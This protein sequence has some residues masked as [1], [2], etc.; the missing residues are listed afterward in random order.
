MSIRASWFSSKTFDSL[1][2]LGLTEVLT[3]YDE[4]G[5]T[6]IV[7]TF[8]VLVVLTTSFPILAIYNKRK[9]AV[10]T[11]V[12]A[13]IGSQSSGDSESANSADNLTKK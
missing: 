5:F 11:M 13:I 3:T 9:P 6:G 10:R 2:F 8:G 7:I 4:K 12:R 1:L